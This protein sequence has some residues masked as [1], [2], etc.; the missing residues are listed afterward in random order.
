[1]TWCSLF[2][3]HGPPGTGL[4]Q[5]SSCT[6]ISTGLAPLTLY[7]QCQPLQDLLFLGPT[8]TRRAYDNYTG[9][10]SR[11]RRKK[12][13]E[14]VRGV[15]WTATT[16]TIYRTATLL[17]HDFTGS[18][19]YWTANRDFTTSDL[20]APHRDCSGLLAANSRSTIDHLSTT[21]TDKQHPN[22]TTRTGYYELSFVASETTHHYPTGTHLVICHISVVSLQKQVLSRFP[23]ERQLSVL[24]GSLSD[25]EHQLNHPEQPRGCGPF[26]SGA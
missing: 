1:V 3:T 9:P 14:Q 6:S 20:G 19:F 5:S 21:M 24:C 23:D 17:D 10:I 4:R 26:S 11:T 2:V 12:Q 7:S 15:H 22:W 8:P 13:I 18:R 16:K 25:D